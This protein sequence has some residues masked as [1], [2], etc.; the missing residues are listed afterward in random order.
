MNRSGTHRHGVSLMELIAASVVA[1]ALISLV[2]QLLIASAKQDRAADARA[3]ALVEL[4]NAAERIRAMPFAEI[5]QAKLDELKLPAKQW[6]DAR[7]SCRMS[8]LEGPPA[9]KRVDIELQIGG[10]AKAD[11]LRL[12]MWR[13]A[14][15]EEAAEE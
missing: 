11:A 13:Y 15:Q 6:P 1:A 9:A 10:N 12:S 2:T 4:G 8:A 3:L 5:T 7:L 14:Y